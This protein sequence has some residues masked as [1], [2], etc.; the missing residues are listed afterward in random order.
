[1]YS[2]C[3]PINVKRHGD[4]S[5][6]PGATTVCFSGTSLDVK[7]TNEC[8][9]VRTKTVKHC[10]RQSYRPAKIFYFFYFGTENDR[11]KVFN[12]K[13]QKKKNKYSTIKFQLFTNDHPYRKLSSPSLALPF[14]KRFSTGFS[15]L[16]LLSQK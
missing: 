9:G 13:H 14:R 8:F 3:G 4:K 15:V 11:D 6:I 2:N 12:K 10:Y 5:S 7:Q 16:I 1:M